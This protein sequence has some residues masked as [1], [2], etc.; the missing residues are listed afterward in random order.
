MHLLRL[1]LKNFKLIAHSKTSVLALILA[2]IIIIF[3]LGLAFNTTSVYNIRVTVYSDHYTELA[4][5]LLGK[6][7]TKDFAVIRTD[8]AKECTEMIKAG[9][10]N[11]CLEL[12]PDLSIEKDKT[13]NII[14][15]VDPSQVNLVWM[16]LDI[17][18]GEISS[19]T[20][21]ISMDLTNIILGRLES[22]KNVLAEKSA[23]VGKMIEAN[24]DLMEKNS[25]I[26]KSLGALDLSFDP[27]KF[28]VSTLGTL[29]NKS[30]K[31]IYD[32]QFTVKKSVS[33]SEDSIS[34]GI[35]IVGNSSSAAKYFNDI[36]KDLNDIDAEMND[37]EN[38]NYTYFSKISY[39]I[40][41]VTLGLDDLKDR[42]EN[43]DVHRNTAI[44][45]VGE[46]AELLDYEKKELA[47]MK[48]SFDELLSGI[49]GVKI[50][51]AGQIVNPISTTIKPV[52]EERTHLNYIF[53]G[54]II[55][56]IMFVSILLAS[57]IV[58]MEKKSKSFLINYLTPEKDITFVLSI[59]FTAL[60]LMTIQVTIIM[61]IS[62]YF[63][64][65]FAVSAIGAIAL[66]LLISISLFVLIGMFIA[67][68]FKAEQ[69]I[70]LVTISMGS[71]LLFLSDII[72][73]IESMPMLIQDIV[74]WNPFLVSEQL[75]KKVMLFGVNFAKLA[76]GIIYLVAL[77]II[78]FIL[79]L[80]NEKLIKRHW[81][82]K[83]FKGIL[84]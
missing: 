80:L 84:K 59:Y 14:F 49:E 51:E 72:L 25:Q 76:P 75:L 82:A 11:I 38:L 57:N 62:S 13:N 3:L 60:L 74:K 63:L 36:G 23:V 54:I 32:M 28:N 16:V 42:L 50:T 35:D 37:I 66:I 44:N 20:E 2:P 81:L 18:S 10:S 9:E 65:S 27:Q 47:A 31:Q 5:T 17:I 67:Y 55:L 29:Q 30:T 83:L 12:P 1:I 41:S 73:P 68:F 45:N 71:L 21:E 22:T 64:K 61:L 46:S 69:T 34:K 43:A 70:T 6:L 52:V 4:E 26:E 8:S 78:I 7:E 33:D 79:I 58:V 24:S 15:H 19:K 48:S 39:L 56:I 77:S 53:A 40:S